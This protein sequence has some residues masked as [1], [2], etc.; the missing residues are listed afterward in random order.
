MSGLRLKSERTDVPGDRQTEWNAENL[1]VTLFVTPEWIQRPLFAEITGVPPG[2]MTARP[3]LQFHQE[4]GNLFGGH[5]RV[6][7]QPGRI[8][9]VLSG[10]PTTAAFDLENTG[11]QTFLWV[12]KLNDIVTGFNSITEK[13]VQIVGTANRAAFA[14]TLGRQTETIPAAMAILKHYLPSIDFDPQIDAD[15]S[16]Q[17]NRPRKT[18]SGRKINRLARWEVVESLLVPLTPQF[19]MPASIMPMPAPAIAARAYI[20]VSTEANVTT[21]MSGTELIEIVHELRLLALEIAENGDLR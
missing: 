17:I 5:L 10:A 15:F 21:Q 4:T 11:M 9:L 8:D 3:Q 16:Y 6:G 19:V 12:G 20:D 2:E 18:P 7:Q 1:R 13:I 14:L